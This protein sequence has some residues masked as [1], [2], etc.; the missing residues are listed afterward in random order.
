MKTNIFM[1]ILSLFVTGLVLCGVGAGVCVAEWSQFRIVQESDPEAHFMQ[2]Y[3]LP[4]GE[5]LYFDTFSDIITLDEN[6]KEGEITLDAVYSENYEFDFEPIKRCKLA[7]FT[8]DK[9]H[10]EWTVK[11]LVLPE[12][13]PSDDAPGDMHYF[14]QMINHLRDKEIYIHVENVPHYSLIVNP[15][16]R[17]RIICVADHDD[18]MLADINAVIGERGEYG[19]EYYDDRDE[20]YDD[21]YDDDY[22]YDEDYYEDM[23]EFEDD[24]D[25]FERDMEKFGDDLSDAIDEIVD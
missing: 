9:S 10:K 15:K 2:V 22:Y 25:E 21:D 7:E 24:M 14:K 11:G 17:D 12:Y 18:L 6:A 8:D 20:Y 13:A 19:N 5:P 3:Q 16:D 4:E 23:S 1:R